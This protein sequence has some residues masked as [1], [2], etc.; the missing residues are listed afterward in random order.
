MVFNGWLVL[1]SRPGLSCSPAH[2]RSHVKNQTHTDIHPLT[3]THTHSRSRSASVLGRILTVVY[4][5]ELV[6]T[7]QLEHQQARRGRVLPLSQERPRERVREEGGRKKK[8]ERR[9]RID[10]N[11]WNVSASRSSASSG[12]KTTQSL[13][14]DSL[15]SSKH[16]R[17]F[18]GRRP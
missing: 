5:I 6:I 3:H 16:S 2:T 8:Q 12:W 9:G 11:V 13:V 17:C 15:V 1:T 14:L 7:L 4:V 10:K 18:S